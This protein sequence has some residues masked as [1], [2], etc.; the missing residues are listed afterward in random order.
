MH[1]TM[2]SVLQTAHLLFY[3]VAS[4]QRVQRAIYTNFGLSENF[5]IGKFLSE[6]TKSGAQILNLGILGVKVGILSIPHISS[7]VRNLPLSVGRKMRL[8][9]LVTF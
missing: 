3:P 7:F 5:R 9:L 4:W 8:A 6:H 1:A 2:L